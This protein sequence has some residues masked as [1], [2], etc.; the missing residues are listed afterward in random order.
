MV[1]EKEQ[2]VPIS[3]AMERPGPWCAG[4]AGEVKHAQQDAKAL[5]NRHVPEHDRQQVKQ[6]P[7]RLTDEMSRFHP[8]PSPDHR[9]Q[10]PSEAPGN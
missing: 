1:I 8:H 6:K 10:P 4:G 9:L 2:G 7:E 5:S 3:G